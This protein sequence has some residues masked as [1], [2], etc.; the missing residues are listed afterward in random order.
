MTEWLHRNEFPYMKPSLV[1]GKANSE[2][3]KARISSYQQLHQN[4]GEDETF[5]FAKGVY[6]THTRNSPMDGSG[7]A[8]EKRFAQIQKGRELI[9]QGL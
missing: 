3:Q 9:F 4:L 1:P 6:S 2:V 8:L 5:C 7:R